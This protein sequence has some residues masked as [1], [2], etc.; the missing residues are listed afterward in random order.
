M[1]YLLTNKH[2]ILEKTLIILIAVMFHSQS[3]GGEYD[4]FERKIRPLFHKHCYECHSLKKEKKKG[5]L[6]LDSRQGWSIGGDSGPAIIPGNPE[7]SLLMRAVSYTDADLRMP[8]KYRLTEDER[9]VLFQ[10]IKAGAPD[11]RVTNV[12]I[13]TKGI[14]LEKGRYFWSFKPVLDQPVPSIKPT[15]SLEV[16][17]MSA[18]DRFVIRRLQEEGIEMVG[19]AKPE[20]LLRRLYYDLIGLPPTIDQ[21][22]Q[23]LSDPSFEAYASLVDELLASPHFG[24]TWGRHWLDVARFAES[25]GGGRSLMFKNAW[26]YRD[27]VIRAFN[28]DKPFNN[29]I[30]EQIAGDLLSGGSREQR[31]D[32]LKATGFLALGPHNYEL[33]DK[34]LLRMEV[35]DEQIDTV[36]QAFLA[37][38][39]GCARCHDHKFDPIPTADYY[40][41]AGIF[42]GTQS[43]VPGNV[44]G[45]VEQ[46]LFPSPQVENAINQHL[47]DSKQ[48]SLD[49]QIARK[50]LER[51]ELELGKSAIVIDNTQSDIIGEWMK[52]TSNKN[53]FGDDYI[54]DKGEGKGEKKVIYSVLLKEAGDYEVRFGYTHG[55][56]RSKNVPVVIEHADG[57]A[58]IR[59]NQR[60][61][62]PIGSNFLVLGR[63][64]F[65]AGKAVVYV[66]NAG[67]KD[68]VIADAVAFVPLGTKK[69]NSDSR[70]SELRKKVDDLAARVQHLK[71]SKPADLPRVMSVKDQAES[72]DWHI[73]VRG[74]I[75]NKGPVVPRGFLKVASRNDIEA[76]ARIAVGSGRL[77]LA[78]W[79]ASNQNPLTRR[80]MVNRIWHH[81]I[82][83]GLVLTTDNFGLKGDTPSHPELLDWL[84]SQFGKDG[85]SVKNIIRHIVLSR[86]YRLSSRGEGLGNVMDPEN[87]LLWRA[88]RKRL[89]AEAMRDS[90]LSVSGNLD[91]KQ[92]GYTI[93][94][95]SQYDLG[96]EFDSSR[97]SVY[98][99]LF[100]NTLMEIFE[101]FD[102]A[103][104]NVVTGRRNETVLPTQ[105]L[106]LLN[107][108][109]M[110]N[111]SNIAG[112]H[113]K[114]MAKTDI[115]RVRLAYQSILAREPS[116]AELE[117]AMKYISA[118]NSDSQNNNWGS[119][120]HSIFS[121][122]QFRYLD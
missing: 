35:V 56:N 46:S 63:F 21:L 16:N 97:R 84:S 102:A 73:H 53:Y 90:I 72:S 114:R 98:V 44:S 68:V 88:N 43:L 87:R 34:E 1:L 96:Y 7:S 119:L 101:V 59:V 60:D 33:Q 80:V 20:V 49:L 27:Y 28:S 82:G 86:T 58:T 103:N 8:P 13:E 50:E 57:V 111:E 115:E 108:P 47:N 51:A 52:S 91:K 113:I 71:K 104:P 109:F 10:W 30:R 24:E 64:K 23:F 92:G 120:I 118:T 61:E 29:F 106:F 121:S 105:A 62:P 122:V 83:Q 37:M 5:G 4:Y 76:Q 36:G 48:A 45:W 65:N 11:P 14:D 9:S 55:T 19:L 95:F 38:T 112:G 15:L 39:I 110:N 99:P 77:E 6:F 75:R 42:R 93:R 116:R 32:Y 85:W 40:A 17:K 70:L 25:S 3:L 26:Q 2:Q 41:M 31:N 12:N 69:N 81:L 54:H 94:K 18:I 107:S 79:I 78:E 66:S 67:T 74:E 100:R 117:L 89:T 22:N